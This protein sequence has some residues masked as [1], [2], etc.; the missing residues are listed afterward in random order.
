MSHSSKPV[1]ADD[2]Y[3]NRRLRLLAQEAGSGRILDVGYAH[4]PNSYFT[5]DHVTGI[6]LEP[7]TS[8][9]PYDETIVGDAASLGALWGRRFDSVVVGELIE[10]LEDPYGFLRGV[11]DLLD[12]GGRLVLST[13]NPV[14]F[15]VVMAEWM[16]TRSRFYAADHTFYFPPRWVDRM[17]ENCGFRVIRERAVGL[18]LPPLRIPLCPIG[19]SYQ[20]VYVAEP[21]D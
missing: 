12:P 18:W 19:L 5:G 17:L 15:P 4:L 2:W 21:V 16:R 20:V 11:R 1:F 3:E 7:P 8:A 10:H 9:V 6:D 14:S 13:P